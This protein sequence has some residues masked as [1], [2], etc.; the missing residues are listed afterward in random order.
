MH[1]AEIIKTRILR[2]NATKLSFV[3]IGVFGE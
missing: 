1:C 3:V 2:T